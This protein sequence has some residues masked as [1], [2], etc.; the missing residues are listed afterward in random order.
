[1][2]F[3]CD[4]F[5][6]NSPDAVRLRKYEHNLILVAMGILIFGL[7]NLAKSLGIIFLNRS[8]FID[9]IRESIADTDV[10][11]NEGLIFIILVLIVALLLSV[12]LIAR[13][14]IGLS[15]IS[16]GRYKRRKTLYLPVTILYILASVV[17]I[18]MD[19]DYYFLNSS[20]TIALEI[21]DSPLVSMM[22]EVT[23]VIMMVELVVYSVRIRRLRAKESTD[24]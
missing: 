6:D 22:I 10:A 20:E 7:W 13:L 9:M 1:M 14:F 4:S 18:Y 12:G 23:S 24:Q 21:S 5:L 17:E 2:D 8:V 3:D 15:A 19:F 16:V 11:A